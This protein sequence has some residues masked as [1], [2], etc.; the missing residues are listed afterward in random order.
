MQ[1]LTSSTTL[2][3]SRSTWFNDT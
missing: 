1:Q 2:A 3:Y